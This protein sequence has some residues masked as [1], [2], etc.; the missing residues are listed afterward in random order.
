MTTL[1]ACLYKSQSLSSEKPLGHVSFDAFSLLLSLTEHDM[2]VGV[3]LG[4]VFLGTLE[5]CNLQIYSSLSMKVVELGFE[6]LQLL[7]SADGSI[8]GKDLLRVDYTRVQNASPGYEGFDQDITMDVSTVI[9][10]TAPEPLLTLYDLIMTTFVPSSPSSGEPSTTVESTTATVQSAPESS[11]EQRAG[12]IR[13]FVK[14]ASVEGGG[15]VLCTRASI[16]RHHSYHYQCWFPDR[17]IILIDCGCIRL[18]ERYHE[19]ARTI[20]EL[21]AQRR[22][23]HRNVVTGLQ[24]T[25]VHRG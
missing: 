7:S 14:L 20:G 21:I 25:D 8:D 24:E 11:S 23:W 12:K 16:D 3:R 10:W 2:K 22:L 17:H 15:F 19:R 9:F 13:L 1:R 5:C 6:P 18:I 4:F